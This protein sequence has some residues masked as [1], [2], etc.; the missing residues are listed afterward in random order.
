MKQLLGLGVLPWLLSGCIVCEYCTTTK[1]GTTWDWLDLETTT[2]SD[3]DADADSDADSD[4]DADTDSTVTHTGVSDTTTV[5]TGQTGD[6]G[7]VGCL[8]I[9][10]FPLVDGIHTAVICA[11][12]ILDNA[13]AFTVPS[14]E[15]APGT[16]Q[17]SV[18]S[19]SGQT[20]SDLGPSVVSWPSL[21]DD[22]W[23]MAMLTGSPAPEGGVL[24]NEC[25]SVDLVTDSLLSYAIDLTVRSTT[26]SD[27]LIG[28]Y[29]DGVEAA[30]VIVPANAADMFVGFG[31]FEGLAAVNL[32]LCT[33][34]L[35]GGVNAAQI[36]VRE[37]I[38]T[39]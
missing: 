7:D 34:L 22:Y 9:E 27:N 24:T 12:N 33:G 13:T 23:S 37:A 39:P 15:P 19:A 20:V 38:I 1:D 36:Q 21:G 3:A 35:E 25:V 32:Q 14:T 16:G 10:V 26:P 2:E 30:Q 29:I 4:A 8:G 6:T 11:G 18:I 5:G 31:Y 28:L 17:W